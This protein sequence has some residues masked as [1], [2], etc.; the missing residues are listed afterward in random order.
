MQWLPGRVRI[1]TKGQDGPIAD[2]VASFVGPK[3]LDTS[4]VANGDQVFYL[5]PG[6]WMILVA[7]D[8]FG[9]ERRELSIAPDQTSMVVIEVELEPAKV[10]VT[11]AEVKI[12]DQINFT[13]GSSEVDA[14]SFGL[15]DEIAN[16][17]L[18]NP[19]IKSV[20]VQGHSDSQ[21]PAA[22]N[23]KLSQSRMETVSNYLVSKGVPEGLLQ[24]KG[25]GEEQPIADN[26]TKEGR[27]VNRRV[28][29]VIL[30][31]D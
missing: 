8:S 16:T 22:F 12:L 29:F 5:A 25:F 17:L 23:L 15:L 27:T 3:E 24:P 14:E 21:G 19:H 1:V 18:A 26:G 10:E 7:A 13:V 28:Q 20:E 30:E 4:P 9:T 31:Q 11:R 2:A 6:D